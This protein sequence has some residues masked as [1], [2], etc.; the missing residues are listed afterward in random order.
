MGNA[1]SATSHV[2]GG[3]PRLSLS[4]PPHVSRGGGAGDAAK[5]RKPPSIANHDSHRSILD[6]IDEL[7]APDGP[8]PLRSELDKAAVEASEAGGGEIMPSSASDFPAGLQRYAL[9]RSLRSSCPEETDLQ[10]E[11][12]NLPRAV[13]MGA[14]D[15]A[16]LLC[17]LLELMDARTVVEVGVFRGTTTLAFARCLRGMMER[18]GKDGVEKRRVIGLDVSEEFAV[19]GKRYWENAGV[20]HL[21]DFRV[22]DAKESLTAMLSEEGLGEN[23]VDLCFIDA[24]KESYD[25]YYE[26]CLRLTKPGGLIVVDN[27]IWS[28]RV[29]LP[30]GVLHVLEKA[31]IEEGGPFQEDARQARSTLAIKT[32]AK[33]ISEDRRVQRVCF[34]TIADGVMIC[35]K[36]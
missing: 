7:R 34:L 11:A 3:V 23:S 18:G 2:V 9:G 35:R 24:D 17:L 6:R 15:E 10:S 32:L 20:S 30:D 19:V 13:M 8:F 16:N 25:D 21:I 22:G 1:H 31:P 29:M 36:L 5:A 27:T 28:G 14:P 12:E 33:K 4:P 26:K